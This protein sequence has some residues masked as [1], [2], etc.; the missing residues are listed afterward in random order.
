M[1]QVSRKQFHFFIFIF[2]FFHAIPAIG[3]PNAMETDDCLGT[4][5]LQ[6]SRSMELTLEHVSA[7]IKALAEEYTRLYE[8]TRPMDE[9]EKDLWVKHALTKGKTMSFR[10]FSSSHAPAFQAPVP[11]YLFYNGPNI[12]SDVT[13]ELKTFVDMVPLFRAAYQTFHYSWVYMTTVD[14]AF[15]IYPYLPLDE[16]VNNLPPTKQDFYRAAD[17]A[18]RRFGWQRPYLD[19]AGA[20]MMVTVSYPVYSRENLLG[21]ISRD[22]TLTQISRKLLK[23][24]AGRS[25]RLI[26]LILDKEGLAIAANRGAAMEEIDRINTR[27]G[28]AI[29]YYRTSQ[30]LRSLGNQKAIS[31]SNHLFNEAG[32]HALACVE[33]DPHSE[34]RHLNLKVGQATHRAAVARIPSTGWLL[35]TIDTH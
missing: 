10:P 16:A 20:G 11:A 24:V 23:P 6:L 3:A 33:K 28:N 5:S 22:I 29:L 12:T 30:G 4:I 19:L 7:S 27:A 26:S 18:G 9:T 14:E 2:L 34:I 32:E 35:I 21:V 1:L 25:G 31:S 15:L 13:R 17:F 8:A